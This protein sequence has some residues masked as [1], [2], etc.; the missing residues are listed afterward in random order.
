MALCTALPPAGDPFWTQSPLEI[1]QIMCD[2]TRRGTSVECCA[3]VVGPLSAAI[4]EVRDSGDIVLGF[5]PGHRPEQLL[6]TGLP[7]VAWANLGSVRVGFLLDGLQLD[8]AG[9]VP[10]C[11]ARMPLAVHRLQRREFFRL[12]SPASLL[13]ELSL[14][15]V[16][17]GARPA[18]SGRCLVPMVDLSEG[19]VCLAWPVGLELS[20]QLGDV[21]EPCWLDLP[22]FGPIRF[23]LQFMNR[24]DDF[25]Q[26][27]G[28]LLGARF[29]GMELEHQ[30]LLRRFLY[31]LQ[32]GVHHHH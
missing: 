11:M 10:A 14:P 31:Q 3:G 15:R 25:R 29:V 21:L 30:R 32:A 4:T 26:T 8:R 22:D 2:L 9:A 1:R 20:I 17:A 7:A 18:Q 5:L 12:P 13:C 23:G 24:L 6:R 27:G 28:P 16:A 19:G